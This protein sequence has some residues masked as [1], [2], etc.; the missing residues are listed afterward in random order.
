MSPAAIQ[1]LRLPDVAL[2]G[3]NLIEASAGTGKTFTIAGLY[4]R[5]VVEQGRT[6]DSILV[7]TFTEA[8]TAELRARI[9][10]RL[11]EAAQ[12]I[13]HDASHATLRQALFLAELPERELALSRLRRAILD[14][15]RAAIFTIHG[16]C[17][18]VLQE[19]AFESGQR[20]DVEVITDVSQLKQQVLADFWRLSAQDLSPVL[21]RELQSRNVDAEKLLAAVE[22]HLHRP[23]LRI[24]GGETPGNIDQGF[25]DLDELRHRL[26]VCWQQHQD[27]VKT[28]FLDNPCLDGRKYRASSRS[29]WL[30]NMAQFLAG[31]ELKPFKHFA[32]FASR[33]LNAA[34]RKNCTAA[35]QHEFFDLCQTYLVAWD[36]LTTQIEQSL[37]YL[38][39]QLL[40]FLNDELTK[41]KSHAGQMAFDDMLLRVAA[42]LCSD[43][44]D[45]LAKAVRQRFGAALIDEFQDTD[46]LQYQIFSRIYQQS[47]CPLFLVG[48]PKQAIYSFRGADLFAYLNARNDATRR[49]TLRRNWRSEPRLIR[50]FNALFERTRAF[51]YDAILFDP[52][53]AADHHDRP[54][55]YDH[56]IPGGGLAVW[57]LPPAD[58]PPLNKHDATALAIDRVA[59][60]IVRLLQDALTGKIKI[61][62][63]P[64]QAGQIAILVRSHHQGTKIQIALRRRGVYSVQ[65]STQSVFASTE[66]MALERLLRALSNPTDERLIRTALATP[67]FGYDGHDLHRLDEDE[68]A[69]ERVVT[70][71][72][73]AQRQ[74]RQRGIY[75][76]LRQL[77]Q[78]YGVAAR[79]LALADGERRLTN[80]YH[81]LE[82]LHQH[83]SPEHGGTEAVI[84]WLALMRQGGSNSGDGVAELRLESDEDLVQIVTLHKSKGLQYPVVFCPFLWDGHLHSEKSQDSL[85][86]HE[87]ETGQ[88]VLDLGSPQGEEA[89]RLAQH[90]ELAESLRLAYVG[91][92]RAMHRCYLVWGL[93]NQA[94]SSPLGWLLHTATD[95]SPALPNDLQARFKNLTFAQLQ[96]R[97]DEISDDTDGA[98]YRL[99]GTPHE[100]RYHGRAD[101]TRACEARSFARVLTVHNQTTSFTALAR[102][103]DPFALAVPDHDAEQPVERSAGQPRTETKDSF[104]FPRGSRAGTCLH[105]LFEHLDFTDPDPDDIQSQCRMTLPRFGFD[106]DWVPVAAQMVTQVLDTPL[107]TAGFRLRGLGSQ[108]R[109]VE[110]AFQY[111][112]DRFSVDGLK[113]LIQAYWL[114]AFPGL[115]SAIQG[116]NFATV[117]GYLRGFIDLIYEDQG[118][119]FILDYKSNWLG[120]DLTAYAPTALTHAVLHEH[121]YLQFLL[122]TLALHRLLAQRLPGY[123][124]SCHCG[125]VY[126]LFLRGMRAAEGPNYGVYFHRPPQPLIQ[127]LDAAIAA[128]AG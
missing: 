104:G 65:R 19:N 121:Y 4:L 90:E 15:D 87:P 60:E 53:L 3:I 28:C 26:A 12:S 105:S 6:V 32:K 66:A 57:L 82:L 17:Q 8:A 93:I 127:A 67:L 80:L 27:S 7:V 72:A 75:P 54:L 100:G 120:D 103:A 52:A 83:T 102:T 34:L 39:R 95:D 10:R 107:N 40:H 41:R 16:F 5:L 96:G 124:Y 2:D 20:F 35:P 106:L 31:T 85:L 43:G 94:G 48:D 13:A 33:E 111:P 119:Y 126:Y 108:H 122:Y 18:R 59:D 1:D 78:H 98:L 58:K 36:S 70:D 88:A 63:E 42:A 101:S 30:V 68:R 11:V 81:L 91:I 79:L 123:D 47:D 56:G 24:V 23:Y 45:A 69:L 62:A 73:E 44:G 50:A 55:L 22:R 116:L 112:I 110:M 29:D 113:D 125:G 109:L 51:V 21:L 46:P 114:D 38:Q 61:G 76:M 71:F 14:F 49:Y 64:L 37:R 117:T 89:H 25:A 128:E 97:L 118:Q 9:R 86:F 115:E 77:L 84:Q 92:T 99:E 74:W